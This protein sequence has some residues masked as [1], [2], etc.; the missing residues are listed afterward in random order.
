MHDIVVLIWQCESI[1]EVKSVVTDTSPTK[2]I[3]S[4]NPEAIFFNKS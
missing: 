3:A 2:K 4:E 1:V